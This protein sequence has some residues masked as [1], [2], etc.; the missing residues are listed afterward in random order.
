MRA[1][2][3]L[4]G[5]WKSF[6][7]FHARQHALDI[8]VSYVAIILAL[9]VLL[10]PPSPVP[11]VGA[12]GGYSA[13]AVL[14][15]DNFTNATKWDSFGDP[16]GITNAMVYDEEGE[17]IYA[18]ME[19][20]GS[21]GIARRC[22]N[23]ASATTCDDDTDWTSAFTGQ[24]FLSLI[25][26]TTGGARVLYGGTES[27]RIYRCD[28]ASSSCD[29]MLDWVLARAEGTATNFEGLAIN[30]GVLF[31]TV[32]SEGTIRMVTCML[33][34][35]CDVDGD[36]STSLPLPGTGVGPLIADATNDIL[37]MGAGGD[38]LRC[39]QAAD[40][41]E[42]D[43]DWSVAT[44]P[45]GTVNSFALD[46]DNGVIYAGTDTQVLRCAVSDGC[47][48]SGE[49]TASFDSGSVSSAVFWDPTTDSIY[50]SDAGSGNLYL[51]EISESGCNSDGD[52]Q[53]AAT[54]GALFM[55]AFVRD[56]STDFL[57]AAG[58][59]GGTSYAYECDSADSCNQTSELSDGGDSA[60]LAYDSAGE[61]LFIVEEG[62]SRVL[63][64]D[65]S[66]VVDGAYPVSVL[67]QVDLNDDLGCN[68]GGSAAA[69][70]LCSPQDVAYDDSSGAER[71]FVADPSNNRVVVYDAS[72]GFTDGESAVN[73]L[74]Q[75]NF[76]DTGC[77]YE[78]TGPDV[79]AASGLQY[80]DGN[81]RLFVTSSDNGDVKVFDVAVI[82]NGE[83][84]VN[85]LG[86]NDDLSPGGCLTAIDGLCSPT[87][88]GYDATGER[89]FVADDDNNRIIVYDVDPTVLIPG[90][91]GACNDPDAI[92][93]LGQADFDSNSSALTAAGLQSPRDAAY[94]AASGLLYVT[95]QDN[96]RIV[97]YDVASISF[98]EDAIDVVGQNDF[99]TA[100]SGT[101][102][103]MV[104]QVDGIAL[105]AGTDEIIVHDGGNARVLFFTVST[106]APPS[107]GGSAGGTY[108]RDPLGE[109]GFT[110]LRILVNRDAGSTDSRNVL[111]TIFAENSET[112][113]GTVDVLLSNDP[114]FGTFLPFR[115][116]VPEV[117]P[118]GLVI[119]NTWPKTVAWDMCFGV[120]EGQPCGMGTK[121]VYARFYV[122]VPPPEPVF[123]QQSGLPNQ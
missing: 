66:T 79:C 8:A 3:I 82:T 115:Y 43:T 23:E 90:C 1:S 41:C 119:R 60:G 69:G 65:L 93:V 76:T 107:G 58:E 83:S 80:D 91:G 21:D 102:A 72:D 39:N 11:Q 104:E 22:F 17:A 120:P 52:W 67:G 12:V 113:S 24:D 105:G 19:S 92:A 50:S 33:T 59:S 5:R 25:L 47:E 15:P 53:R 94:D 37:Y 51:C 100:D 73:V 106:T 9:S 30:D 4:T 84:A 81:Q 46:S 88:L 62:N 26:D 13:T 123:R 7:A 71:L 6:R 96:E 61:R 31:A 111:V 10:F 97:V 103:T 64:Y 77:P 32:D 117:A 20:G 40:G 36:F 118:D 74:G 121:I 16:G 109:T 99:T 101:S 57:Y 18:A 122:N 63:V 86:G 49:W 14:G 38:I 110:P 85:G 116:V 68:Q 98:G 42:T 78:P 27:A 112:F 34:S 95:D 2:E 114:Q 75:A 35:D 87:G 54:D 55:R 44:S 28:I 89:L 108:K 29:S 48:V 45:G 56:T 70:T